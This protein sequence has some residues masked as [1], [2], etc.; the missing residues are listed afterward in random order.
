MDYQVMIL[1]NGMD[2]L[3]LGKTGKRF[4]EHNQ[5]WKE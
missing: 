2:V 5:K 1:S 4:S 3:C